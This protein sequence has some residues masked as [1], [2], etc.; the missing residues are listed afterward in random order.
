MTKRK[1]SSGESS[2]NRSIEQLNNWIKSVLPDCDDVQT[3]FSTG[4]NLIRLLQAIRPNCVP[5]GR[6]VAQ[7]REVRSVAVAFALERGSGG[8]FD[9]SSLAAE[10]D[11]KQK[12][13]LLTSIATHIAH[14]KLEDWS[15][16]AGHAEDQIR[17]LSRQLSDCQAQIDLEQSS[18]DR[19]IS[20]HEAFLAN[21]GRETSPE[22]I[23]Q[24]IEKLSHF[25]S[26]VPESFITLIDMAFIAVQTQ[27]SL[28]NTPGKQLGERIV[29]VTCSCAA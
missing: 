21:R 1:K 23:A 25:S 26:E 6:Y 7:I 9:G 12:I 19:L 29:S 27:L 4:I 22:K 16:A 3:D 24:K 18:T 8:D 2:M 15:S 17:T 14:I 13:A 20:S 11:L 28:S 10:G 5:T